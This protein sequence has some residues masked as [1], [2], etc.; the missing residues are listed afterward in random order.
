MWSIRSW[1]WVCILSGIW[2]CISG[3]SAPTQ[4]PE[5]FF[6][7]VHEKLPDHTIVTLVQTLESQPYYTKNTDFSW[8][9]IIDANLFDASFSG[10]NTLSGSMEL[11]ILS[12]FA[13]G[14]SQHEIHIQWNIDGKVEN[15]ENI[16]ID[17]N[18]E[19]TALV[20]SGNQ[21]LMIE[22]FDIDQS[23]REIES[24]ELWEMILETQIGKWLKRDKI[25]WL[26][27]LHAHW[28]IDRINSDMAKARV[29]PDLNNGRYMS[30]EWQEVTIESN[31]TP[32]TEKIELTLI[33]EQIL[34]KLVW[35]NTWVY[36]VNAELSKEYASSFD[37]NRSTKSNGRKIKN[38]LYGILTFPQWIILTL[39][40]KSEIEVSATRPK[41]L[42]TP[43]RWIAWEEVFK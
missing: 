31:Y 17:I 9:F 19:L 38:N 10:D 40:T 14:S 28:W 2:L 8:D 24:L 3:C 13:A 37:G 36:Q 30:N 21:F 32:T 11:E 4:S 5:W 18:I 22:W 20:M 35:A 43:V 12:Y 29:V 42:P 7:M 39:D 34:V 23:W 15:N 25:R 41:L 27:Y 33:P 26:E 1:R 6:G 16:A